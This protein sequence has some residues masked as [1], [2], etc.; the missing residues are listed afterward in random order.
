MEN[1]KNVDNSVDRTANTYSDGYNLSEELLRFSGYYFGLNTSEDLRNCLSF[2]LAHYFLLRGQNA[3]SS[4]LADIQMIH[5][6]NEGPTKCPAL[7]MVMH[8]GK[9]NK[10]GKTEIT[11]CIRN[12]LVEICPVMMFSSYM[13]QR[14][15]NDGESAINFTTSKD[16]FNTKMLKADRNPLVAWKYSSHYDAIK[17]TIDFLEVGSTKVIHFGRGSGARMADLAG[18]GEDE[19]RR[20]GRWNNS[21]MNGAY[22]TGL[23]RESMRIGDGFPKEQGHFYLLRT[24]FEPPVELQQKVYSWV[25][26]WLGRIHLGTAESSNSAISILKMLMTFC[27]T[28]LQDAVFMKLKYPHHPIFVNPLFDSELFVQFSR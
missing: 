13:F 7:V 3:R 8:N 25:D 14:F 27:V 19:I 12:K 5:L 11:G 2:F 4:D 18:V 23:P 10:H 6:K 16:W 24:I 21:S 22:L 15:H 28:F 1:K 20:Q 9:T 26:G 17:K